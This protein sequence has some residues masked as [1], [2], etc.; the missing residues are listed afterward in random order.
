MVGSI[1]PAAIPRPLPFVRIRHRPHTR[2]DLLFLYDVV[3]RRTLEPA[4]QAEMQPSLAKAHATSQE[5][6]LV[7]QWKLRPECC[8]GESCE[9][10]PSLQVA[11]SPS[12]RPC[13]TCHW[14]GGW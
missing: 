8:T 4:F 9:D 6:S 14:P 3:H 12:S 5:S 2:C 10:L 13:T 7:A 1:Y 11:T